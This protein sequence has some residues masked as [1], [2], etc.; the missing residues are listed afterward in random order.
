MNDRRP[1]CRKM[2]IRKEP[3]NPKGWEQERG[4]KRQGGWPKKRTEVPV[5]A[6]EQRDP[7]WRGDVCAYPPAPGLPDLGAPLP[8]FHMSLGLA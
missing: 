5:C 7:P 6:H 3:P 1:Q 2:E 4:R 8:G